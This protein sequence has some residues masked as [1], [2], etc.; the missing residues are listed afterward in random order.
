MT[1]THWWARWKDCPSDRPNRLTTMTASLLKNGSDWSNL[2]VAEVPE[3]WHALHKTFR[4]ISGPSRLST[5][6]AVHPTYSPSRVAGSVC[7]ARQMR[8]NCVFGVGFL[9]TFACKCVCRLLDTTELVRSATSGNQFSGSRSSPRLCGKIAHD[10][11]S[12]ERQLSR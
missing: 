10:N 3:V 9:K 11:V 5:R 1:G 12:E 6:L 2:W 4:G 7:G 8:A